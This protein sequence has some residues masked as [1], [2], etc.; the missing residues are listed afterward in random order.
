MR[1]ISLDLAHRRLGYISEARV[2]ALAN[3]QAEDLKLIPRYKSHKC[4]YY[5]AGKIRT[6]PYPRT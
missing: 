6:L 1:P 5:I 3:G 2:R 4:D